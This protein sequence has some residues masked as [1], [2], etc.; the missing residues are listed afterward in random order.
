MSGGLLRAAWGVTP[1][2]GLLIALCLYLVVTGWG[3]LNDGYHSDDWRHLTGASPL[4]TAVEG[5]DRKLVEL[6]RRQSVDR[7]LPG[8]LQSSRLHRLVARE[9]ESLPGLSRQRVRLHA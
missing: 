9:F 4:W 5:R 3:V 8:A 7:H 2:Q 6:P 1:K